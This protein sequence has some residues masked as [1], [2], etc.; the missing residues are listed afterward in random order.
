MTIKKTKTNIKIG[1]LKNKK[2][3]KSK[4]DGFSKSLI[5]LS[6]K[7]DKKIKEKKELKKE[8]WKKKTKFQALKNKIKRIKEVSGIGPIK[9]KKIW[10]FLGIN[11][12]QD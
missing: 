12:P 3:K 7:M 4:K 8:V 9:A 1:V 5:F 10:K 11:N 6:K 2:E